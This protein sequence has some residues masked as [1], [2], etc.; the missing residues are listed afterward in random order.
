MIRLAAMAASATSCLLLSLTVTFI[1]TTATW[2]WW[3]ARG[4]LPANAAPGSVVNFAVA[5][6]TSTG[7]TALDGSVLVRLH[8]QTYR[9][10]AQH[11]QVRW[12]AN[13]SMPMGDLNGISPGAILQV[14]GVTTAG[15]PV[16]AQQLTVLTNFVHLEPPA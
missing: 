8:G 9:R 15:G 13:V 14:R 10:G 4:N 1:L 16:Q 5:V 7:P 3:S 12:G 2:Q 11:I 6:D